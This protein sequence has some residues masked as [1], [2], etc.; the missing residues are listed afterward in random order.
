M[1]H[2]L[3]EASAL[4]AEAAQDQ[5]SQTGMQEHAVADT[6]Q[7]LQN[8]SMAAMMAT[9]P[10]TQQAPRSSAQAPVPALNRQAGTAEQPQHTAAEEQLSPVDRA[11]QFSIEIVRCRAVCPDW[12]DV[13]LVEASTTGRPDTLVL[14]IPYLL[15]Q[16]PPQDPA[17]HPRRHP[18]QVSNSVQVCSLMTV[19]EGIL[20]LS[21]H[22]CPGCFPCIVSQL[23]KVIA[24]CQG[25]PA[26]HYAP[27]LV[28]D[29]V[30][31]E[32][33]SWR[34]ENGRVEI[35]WWCLLWSRISLVHLQS[36]EI[37][38]IYRYILAEL[39]C[40][41]HVG[42]NG[43]GGSKAHSC[44]FRVCGGGSAAAAAGGGH[45]QPPHAPGGGVRP[46]Q[47]ARR[48]HFRGS[49]SSHPKHTADGSCTAGA[50]RRRRQGAAGVFVE[51]AVGQHLSHAAAAAGIHWCYLSQQLSTM[52]AIIMLQQWDTCT[53]ALT[54]MA[55]YP[56]V[57]SC[58]PRSLS[59]DQYMET[60]L[61][62]SISNDDNGIK[63]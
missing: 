37:D 5:P 60:C 34:Q 50:W 49:I 14:G 27:H 15:L 56:A 8:D 58:L 12:R 22:H 19:R 47:T 62:H 46:R 17:Q 35:V 1:R 55:R 24:A 57:E 18:V 45:R 20:G 26:S 42:G 61:T 28:Q 48:P 40:L 13:A 43:T 21:T 6:E 38:D 7:Q 23:E 31:A 53:E 44:G 51:G 16:L 59:H 33:E 25:C 3:N 9:P 41:D 32:N 29:S 10:Q 4:A 39:L 30:A 2:R 36:S 11:D 52:S 63:K 54:C